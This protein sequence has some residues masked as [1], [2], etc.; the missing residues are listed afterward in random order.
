VLTAAHDVERS[1][2]EI[3]A[4][5]YLGKPFEIAA[6]EAVVERQLR[7]AARPQRSEHA[8]Q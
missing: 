3:G 4:S 1:A 8:S 6:L 7:E 2:H 5:G